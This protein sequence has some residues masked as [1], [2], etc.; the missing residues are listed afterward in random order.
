MATIHLLVGTTMGASEYI[1]DA[2]VPYIEEAGF[3]T[4]IHNPPN[5]AALPYDEAHIWLVVTSTHGAGDYPESIVEFATQLAQQQPNLRG[6]PYAVIA[7]G[8]SSYDT[9]C[10][11]GLKMDNQLQQLGAVQT[12]DPLT[13]DIQAYPIPEDAAEQWIPQWLNQL[14]Q[15]QK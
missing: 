5:L 14:T 10:E 15:Y 6:L 4:H 7:L 13:I 2:L 11:A 8:D 9:F 12:A 1:A 3:S